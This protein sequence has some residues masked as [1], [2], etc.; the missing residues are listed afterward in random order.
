MR[1]F[2]EKCL[3][4]VSCRLTAKELLKD[5][6]LQIED[7]GRPIHEFNEVDP[8]PRQ[9]LLYGSHHSSS[10]LVNGYSSCHDYEGEY[11]LDYYQKEFETNRIDDFTC[12]V[13]RSPDVAISIKGRREDDGIFLR[14][15]ITDKEG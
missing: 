9:P 5:P 13:E 10:L 15:R 6:F 1:H 4:T 8:L 14:L 12:E 2:V 7:Y 11:D 3:A